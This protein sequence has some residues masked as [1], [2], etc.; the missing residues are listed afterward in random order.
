MSFQKN[1]KI[2]RIPPIIYENRLLTNFKYK[3]EL[4]NSFFAKQCLIIDNGSEIFIKYHVY[5]KE[6]RKKLYKIFYIKC[7][8]KG[9]FPKGWK[10]AV[11]VPVHNKIYK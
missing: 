7:L 9:Y 8:E 5:W 4:F 6:N 11:V 2:P 10:K 1:K 3:V